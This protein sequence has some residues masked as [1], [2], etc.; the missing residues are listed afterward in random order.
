MPAKEIYGIV[1]LPDAATS[2]ALIGLSAELCR[3]A[4]S[5]I[6]LGRATNLP[7]VTVV[8]IECGLDQAERLWREFVPE[9]S[10]GIAQTYALYLNARDDGRLFVGASV[11]KSA[12]LAETQAAAVRLAAT[13]GVTVHTATGDGYWPHITLGLWSEAPPVSLP[14]HAAALRATFSI[15]PALALMSDTNRGAVVRVVSD[16]SV[17]VRFDHQRPYEP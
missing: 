16:R 8:H 4:P 15:R 10:A 9:L 5:S 3:V 12:A 7:H 13:H 14:V 17:S 2:Q 1:L 6:Q 11:H